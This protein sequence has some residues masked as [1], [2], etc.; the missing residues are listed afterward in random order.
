M[1]IINPKISLDQFFDRLAEAQSS[2]LMLDYDGTLAPFQSERDKAFPYPGMRERLKRLVVSSKTRTVV[3]SGR[4][5]SDLMRLLSLEKLPEMWGCHGAEYYIHGK[6]QT[7]IELPPNA[8]KGFDD[9]E[10][11][12]EVENL[13]EYLEKKPVGLA[14]HWRGKSP[15][16]KDGIKAKIRSAWAEKVSEYG[17]ILYEFDGGLELRPKSIHKGA[18]VSSV[19]LNH[20][21]DSV[22]AYLGDDL[23]DED[24][25]EALDNRGLRILVQKESRPTK[26]D[27]RLIPPEELLSFL[28]QWLDVIS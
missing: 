25:F 13:S 17:L 19:L 11:W 6:S 7:V 26:A 22:I 5:I 12:A 28:D 3:V 21:A 8:A 18:V 2:L 27:V 14:F 10:K 4:A 15:E 24:A 9:V 1:E 23:T 16:L 20:P